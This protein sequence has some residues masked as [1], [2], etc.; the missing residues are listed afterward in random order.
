MIYTEE[1]VKDFISENSEEEYRKF[2]S[3]LTRTAY[4]V[5]GIRVPIMRKFAKTLASCENVGEFL[6]S[7]PKCYEEAMIKGLVFGYLRRY[8]DFFADLERFFS[9]IDDWAVCDVACGNV[10]RKD[11]EYLEKCLEYA[12][13]DHIWTARWGIVA[14]MSFS[15]K[16]DTVRKAVYSIKAQDYYI[17]MALAWLIQVLAV[18]NRPLAE[19]FILS[20]NISD[21]VKK[22][23]VRKIRDSFRI[24]GEDKEYF[25]NIVRD[26]CSRG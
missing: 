8:Q 5:N 4:A 1:T 19:E 25:T 10:K 23:A 18:K 24:S 2:H 16:S 22:F 13:S 7:S 20:P 12:G 14:M 17:D 11:A 9:E 3:R 6:K 15:E 26:N 21:K